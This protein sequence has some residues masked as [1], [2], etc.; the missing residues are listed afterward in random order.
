M[1]EEFLD[2]AQVGAL[3]EQ[4]RGESVAEGVGVRIPSGVEQARVFFYNA[5]HGAGAK[6]LAGVIE[7]D[8]L[9]GAAPGSGEQL[10]AQGVVGFEHLARL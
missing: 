8:G 4:V 5:V 9:S 2:G 3:G 6:A 1:A 10:R 7:E